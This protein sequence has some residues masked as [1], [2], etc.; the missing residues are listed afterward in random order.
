MSREELNEVI[1][2]AICNR[3]DNLQNVIRE[4]SKITD[5]LAK[6]QDMVYTDTAT[7]DQERIL[8]EQQREL[9]KGIVQ[10]VDALTDTLKEVVD[11][12][13]TRSWYDREVDASIKY[14]NE[15]KF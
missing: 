13:H 11:Q 14:E 12:R 4:A 15:I 1:D 2:K 9:E 10:T 7:T 8:R 5:E 6:L 3:L